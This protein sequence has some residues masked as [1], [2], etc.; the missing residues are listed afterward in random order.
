MMMDGNR[1]Y[2]TNLKDLNSTGDS[3]NALRNLVQDFDKIIEIDLPIRKTKAKSRYIELI[4]FDA[5][6][7]DHLEFKGYIRD[8]LDTKFKEVEVP[9]TKELEVDEV[10]AKTCQQQEQN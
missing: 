4:I 2:K 3:E 9:T 8:V 1:V 5:F 6:Y 10:K 7:D